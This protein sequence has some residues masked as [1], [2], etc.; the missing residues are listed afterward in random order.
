MLQVR[1][2]SDLLQKS[3]GTEYSRELRVQN[4][5]RDFAIVLQVPGEIDDGHAPA[6]E[7]ALDCVAV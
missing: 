3:F 7:L 1:G 4:F 5:Y 2:N 6:A